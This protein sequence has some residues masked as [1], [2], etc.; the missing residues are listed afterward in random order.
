M[1]RRRGS[2]PLDLQQEEDAAVIRT[3]EAFCLACLGLCLAPIE[4]GPSLPG[5]EVLRSGQ[6]WWSLATYS[7]AL[8]RGD[9]AGMEKAARNLVDLDVF[10][11]VTFF[12]H[13]LYDG[14]MNDWAP[15][16]RR[17][18]LQAAAATAAILDTMADPGEPRMDGAPLLFSALLVTGTRYLPALQEAE[19]QGHSIV[20]ERDSLLPL[21]LAIRGSL[22][23]GG[24]HDLTLKSWL[25]GSE[26]EKRA[27]EA[28]YYAFMAEAVRAFGTET[29]PEEPQ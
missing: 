19:K 13:A 8:D 6:A 23:L 10:D 22:P 5:T 21:V 24:D 12:N 20:S 18:P 1:D 26:P 15:R 28:Q 27:W 11:A 17:N 25:Q 2:R 4:H 16:L 14:S 7:D 29:G 3:L 9:Q